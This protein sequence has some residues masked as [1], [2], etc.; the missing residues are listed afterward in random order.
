M[1]AKYGSDWKRIL[2]IAVACYDEQNAALKY[3]IKIASTNQCKY[4]DLPAS[5][6]DPNQGWWS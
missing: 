5:K 2:G 6:S 4:E 1:K 3:P